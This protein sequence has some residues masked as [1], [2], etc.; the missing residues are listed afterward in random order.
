MAATEDKNKNVIE[1]IFKI[2]YQPQRNEQLAICGDIPQF[3]RWQ[4]TKALKMV[5]STR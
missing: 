1:V 3:G 4:P 2:Q 5:Q